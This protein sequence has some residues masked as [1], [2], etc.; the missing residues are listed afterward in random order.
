MCQPVLH[1]MARS[2]AK[3]TRDSHHCP[4]LSA[5][6]LHLILNTAQPTNPDAINPMPAHHPTHPSQPW[7]NRSNPVCMHNTL[8][9]LSWTRARR[10]LRCA[11]STT[12]CARC[13]PTAG[14]QCCAPCSTSCASTSSP[15]TPPSPPACSWCV[16]GLVGW[17]DGWRGCCGRAAGGAAGMQGCELR[18]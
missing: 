6:W 7:S 1:L 9:R 18:A 11:A 5:P 4:A 10:W 8:R 14:R 16:G 2:W 17:M 15:S 3:P 13:P 12:R